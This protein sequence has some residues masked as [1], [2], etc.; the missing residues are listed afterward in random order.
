MISIRRLPCNLYA[1]LNAEPDAQLDTDGRA[2]GRVDRAPWIS[3]ETTD[4]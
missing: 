1:E 4:N 2:D 3:I